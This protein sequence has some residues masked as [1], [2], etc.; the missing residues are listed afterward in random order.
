M[1][2]GIIKVFGFLLILE[3]GRGFIGNGGIYGC[4]DNSW[5]LI[6]GWF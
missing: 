4:F 2:L 6:W 1:I 3:I 5:Y